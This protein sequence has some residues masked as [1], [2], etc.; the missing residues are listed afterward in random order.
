MAARDK[1]LSG[2]RTVDGQYIMSACCKACNDFNVISS[3]SP[4]P[5]E[6]K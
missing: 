3:A 2:S 6:T 5:K 4:G 1:I